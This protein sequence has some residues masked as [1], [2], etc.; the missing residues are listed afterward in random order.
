L[1]WIAYPI[2]IFYLVAFANIINLTDGLDGLAAGIVA[3]STA[4]LFVLAVTRGGAEAAIVAAAL[5]GACVA[6]LRFNFYPAK[7]FIGDSGS[8]LIGFTLGLVSLFATVRS[9]ALIT[10]LVPLAIAGIPIIDTF[11]AIVRRIR[12]GRSPIK[13]DSEHMHHRFINLGLDQRTTVLIMY[14]LNVVLALCAIMA[15]QYS[16]LVRIGIFVVLALIAIFLTWRLGLLQSVLQH[17][18]SHREKPPK[19]EDK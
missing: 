1:G 16:G 6:F 12:A 8:L 19:R 5:I 3:I 11:S 10:M 13:A 17:H 14:G 2:S 15:I 7:I 9:S 4:A 18:Y